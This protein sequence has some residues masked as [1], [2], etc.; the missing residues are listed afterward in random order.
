MFKK[1]QEY[2]RYPST[3]Q[4]VVKVLGLIGGFAG[5]SVSPELAAAI[6]GAGVALS[7]LI[8]VFFSDADTAAKI[9]KEKG[10]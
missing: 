4:G 10:E 7:G 5:F 1:I 3:W 9:A 2:L 6:V 8:D